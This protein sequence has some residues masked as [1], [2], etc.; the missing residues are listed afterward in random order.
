MKVFFLSKWSKFYLEIGLKQ[1]CLSQI[2][3][4]QM[5]ANDRN[6]DHA[7]DGK[8]C[9]TLTQHRL[10]MSSA[11]DMHSSLW[12][13]YRFNYKWDDKSLFKWDWKSFFAFCSLRLRS[14]ANI[15]PNSLSF[16]I[17][18]GVIQSVSYP[19]HRC[20]IDMTAEL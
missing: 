13:D 7:N 4:K 6:T 2:M 19:K 9:P 12:F 14:N 3:Q 11:L 5:L 10:R 18:K 15:A 20:Y 17:I 8:W 1:Y 16:A